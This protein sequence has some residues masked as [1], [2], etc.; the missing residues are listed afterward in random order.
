MIMIYF[1][2][3]KFISKILNTLLSL[4]KIFLY[5]VIYLNRI[6][7]NSLIRT[8]ILRGSS[9]I[10]TGNKAK[11]SIG[12][13]FS[14]RR[15]VCLRISEGELTIGN[16]IFMNNN[17]S[18]NCVNKINIGNDCLF[19]ENVKIYDHDHYFSY[20][21]PIR[22]QGLKC[23]PI[24]IGNNVWIGSNVTILKGVNIGNNVVIGAGVVV[25]KD[26]PDNTIVYTQPELIL[27]SIKYKEK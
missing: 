12:S 7:F 1:E 17:V 4:Y 15:Y 20:N 3:M 24:E 19:G 9:I 14:T 13:N 16:N 5:K 27:K 6:N 23:K 18:I 2:C 8:R 25:R 26:I 11:V 21:E 10:I 22:E